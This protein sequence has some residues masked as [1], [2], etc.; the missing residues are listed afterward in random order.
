[1]KS[2]FGSMGTRKTWYVLKKCDEGDCNTD[3]YSNYV[4]EIHKYGAHPGRGRCVA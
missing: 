3:G 2:A 4:L 1:M